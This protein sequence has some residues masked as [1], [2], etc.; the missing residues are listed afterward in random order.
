MKIIYEL[1]LNLSGSTKARQH[2][3][4]LDLQASTSNKESAVALDQYK[5]DLK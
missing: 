1:L 3:R 4:L 5:D 2:T